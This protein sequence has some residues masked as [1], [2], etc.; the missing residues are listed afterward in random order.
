MSGMDIG[1]PMANKKS[2]STSSQNCHVQF[3]LAY[4]KNT[5][6]LL[7]GPLALNTRTEEMRF[8][9]NFYCRLARNLKKKSLLVTLLRALHV[10]QRIYVSLGNIHFFSISFF[11]SNQNI[12]NFHIFQLVY[13]QI[14]ITKFLLVRN[15]VRDLK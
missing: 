15:A 14:T 9:K 1:F 4:L 3:L 10:G 8:R 12:F 2:H 13:Y 5:G 6:P 11:F 7:I